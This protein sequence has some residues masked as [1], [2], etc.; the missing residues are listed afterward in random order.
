MKL[1]SFLIVYLVLFSISCGRGKVKTEVK[2]VPKKTYITVPKFISVQE[3]LYAPRAIEQY[4]ESVQNYSK[5]VAKVIDVKGSTF[6]GFFISSDGLFL[7]SGTS[8]NSK[9]CSKKLCEGYKIILNNTMSGEHK[10]FKNISLIAHDPYGLNFS[11]LKISLAD[12]E[13]VPF[14]SLNLNPQI[15]KLKLTNLAYLGHPMG[16]T[17]HLGKSE[18]IK[19][20]NNKIDLKAVS[21]INDQGAPVIDQ[22]S[23]EVVAMIQ[24]SDKQITSS[25]DKADM[26]YFS[27]GG[28]VKTIVEKLTNDSFI[29]VNSNRVQLYNKPKQG[30]FI[31]PK[32]VSYTEKDLDRYKGM[33]YT[34]YSLSQFESMFEH[35]EIMFR[36]GFE[37]EFLNSIFSQSVTTAKLKFNYNFINEFINFKYFKLNREV[38]LPSFIE[39]S[40]NSEVKK[41]STVQQINYFYF[42]SEEREQIQKKCQ[43]SLMKQKAF[44]FSSSLWSCLS[45]DHPEEKSFIIDELNL[46]MQKTNLDISFNQKLFNI[47][48]VK[49]I[50]SKERKRLIKFYEEK[51]L[52]SKDLGAHY[53]F[54]ANIFDSIFGFKLKGTFY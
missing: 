52:N 10:V 29:Q 16:A 20:N 18:F 22:E 32:I 33:A 23:G 3:S 49:K 15:Q 53:S 41:L 13:N 45:L 27:Q 26:S 39:S 24:K 44:N 6:T 50:N 35:L 34:N 14:L 36:A 42:S 51:V 1:K 40:F 48:W 25:N 28:L 12:K 9:Y 19:L 47:I 38:Q 4:E 17:L 8:I 21:F 7:T 37:K 30:S 54:N 46:E 43:E 2:R 11:L 31:T 5:A